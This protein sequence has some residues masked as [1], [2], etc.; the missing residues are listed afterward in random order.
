MNLSKLKADVD[1]AVEYAKECE[2]SPGDVQVSIQVD[3]YNDSVHSND[4]ELHYDNDCDASGCVIVGYDE[5]RDAE[6]DKSRDDWVSVDAR[7]PDDSRSHVLVFEKIYEQPVIGA[8]F[9][10][11]WHTEIADDYSDVTHWM[12]L[13]DKPT[14]EGAE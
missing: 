4:V 14:D 6:Q 7:L 12:P 13:P 8:Y 5:S 9:D 10:G 1:R 3:T 2:I 11:K